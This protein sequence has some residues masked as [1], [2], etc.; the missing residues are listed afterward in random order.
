MVRLID[1]FGRQ[2][3][4]LRISI[5]D[6][7]N[8]SC[9]YCTP[10]EGACQIP[11]NEILTYEEILRLAE[12]A[13]LAGISKIRLTGGEPLLRKGMVDLCRMLANIEGLD[14]LTLTTN[15]VLL[16]ELALPLVEAGVCRINISLDTLKPERFKKITGRDL[17]FRVLAGIKRSE[18]VGLYPIKINT[19]LMRGINEDEIEDLARLTLKKPYH[20]R[21]IEL[22]PIESSC[23]GGNGSLFVPVEE[24]VKRVKNIA[25][26]DLE[27]KSESFGPARLCTP[28]GGVGKVG[29]IAPLSWHFCDSC[30][31]M[32]LTAD[33]K[34]RTCL[35]SE[36][37]LNIKGPLRAGASLEELSGIFKL[38]AMRKPRSHPLKETRGQR[39][40]GRT[41][42]AIG[43]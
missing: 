40:W 23:F 2:I 27:Y 3:D 43:G 16:H 20:V 31:R 24:V 25:E 9:R 1:A 38:A 15:G 41:M 5:T 26:L 12:A 32:R 30:N 35:F 4:Y 18:E 17:F 13:V 33:G 7:C 8:L 28:K 14:S 10:F 21:F 34:L 42:R 6:R 37:E 39:G 11:H 29:F 36:E 19:V 22:M